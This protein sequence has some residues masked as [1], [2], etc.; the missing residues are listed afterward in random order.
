MLA[1][2]TQDDMAGGLESLGRDRGQPDE[3]FLRQVAYRDLLAAW[4]A[5]AR[6]ANAAVT[7]AERMNHIERSSRLYTYLQSLREEMGMRP[8]DSGCC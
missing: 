7:E 8:A 1:E 5:A 3:V 6:Q 2:T 4:Q